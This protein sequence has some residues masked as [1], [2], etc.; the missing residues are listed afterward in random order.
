MHNLLTPM[1]DIS[2][3]VTV[4]IPPMVSVGEEDGMVQ[5]CA[6]LSAVED[7]ERDLTIT[8]ATSNGTGKH[9]IH[10]YQS[11]IY[12]FPTTALSGTDYEAVTSDV[13]FATRSSDGDEEC[14][15]ITI[16]EDDALETSETFTVTLTTSDLDVMI[17]TNV[18]TVIIL[19]NDGEYRA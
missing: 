18:T 14:V 10:Y 12:S 13:I 19:D 7:T 15:N 3:A 11:M 17:D 8:L 1:N 9:V 4:S 2:T 5:V 16:L 6:T